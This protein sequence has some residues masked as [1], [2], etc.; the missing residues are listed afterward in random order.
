MAN[1]KAGKDYIGVGCGALIVDKDDRVLLTRRGPKSKNQIGWWTQP[2]GT[3]E[4][5]ETIEAAIM[6]EVEEELGIKINLIEMLCYTDHVMPGEGQHWVSIGWLAKIRSGKPK[7]MESEKC[8]GL[9]WFALDELP[10]PL[11]ETT[12]NTTKVLRRKLKNS[13]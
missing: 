1:L 3:V 13:N 5:G 8:D 12:A 2:G 4:F 11:S 7:I 6:R 9:K 10:S